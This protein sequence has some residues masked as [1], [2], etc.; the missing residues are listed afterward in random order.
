MNKIE[1]IQKFRYYQTLFLS[2]MVIFAAQI[3]LNLFIDNFKIS[4]AIICLPAFLFLLDNFALL[5]VTLISALGVFLSRI[6]LYWVQHGYL[7]QAA[8]SSFPEMIF[9]LVYGLLLYIYTR[10]KTDSDFTVSFLIPLFFMDYLSNLSELLLRIHMQAFE[11]RTQLS[12]LLVALARTLLLWMILTIFDRYRLTLMNREHAER[13]QR[14]MVLISRLNGEVIWMQKNTSLIESTMNTSY[15]LYQRLTE[16]SEDSTLSR[17]ALTVARDIHEIK[18]EYLLIMRGLSEALQTEASEEGMLISDI[19]SILQSALMTEAKEMD[20]E[21]KILIK[22]N[23]SL[24]TIKPYLLLSVFHNLFANAL[25]ASEKPNPSIR[26]IQTE[27]NEDYIFSITDDGPGIQPDFQSQVFE[28]GF[29]TKINFDTG[30]INRGL[31]LNIVKDIIEQ[32]L[33]GEIS[34]SSV[35]GKTTFLIHIPKEKLEVRMP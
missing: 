34:L 22:C 20:K 28:P 33:N 3:N 30:A 14:L 27:K 16:M 5:P 6:L 8:L 2:L 19:C 32:E 29:S 4:I 12:I 10:R 13:Y 11:P 25:E 35:P 31:G 21:P 7:S 17:D 24:Y 23:S 1:S 26:L 9:Y 15:Q 18:K